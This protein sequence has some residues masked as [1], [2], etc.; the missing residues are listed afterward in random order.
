MQEQTTTL[1]DSGFYLSR[2]KDTHIENGQI[3]ITLFARLSVKS[4]QCNKNVWV[5]VEEVAWN[6]ASRRLQ[7]LPNGA[8]C[9][10]MSEPVFRELERISRDQMEILYY[11]TPLYQSVTFKKLG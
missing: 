8:Y 7:K 5:E 11:L 1:K 4:P 3:F 10:R 2:V 9:Y 6:Q